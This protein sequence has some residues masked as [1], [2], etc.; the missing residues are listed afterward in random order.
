MTELHHVACVDDDA[1]ILFIA[2]IALQTVGKFRASLLHGPHQALRELATIKPDLLLLD[3]MMP[4]LDGPAVLKE[5]QQDPVLARIPVI[6]MTARVQSSE[7]DYYLALGAIGVVA[8]PFDPMTLAEEIR[9][10]WN[11]WD[12]R[13]N[14][15]STH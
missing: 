12:E 5:M 4:E 7:I 3:V 8:K 1:D 13:R 11:N 15:A 14:G 6:F 9:T 10:I 2:E